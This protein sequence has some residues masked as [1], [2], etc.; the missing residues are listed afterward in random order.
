MNFQMHTFYHEIGNLLLRPLH[1]IFYMTWKSRRCLKTTIKGTL[2]MSSITIGILGATGYTGVELA[3][4]LQKHSHAD[5]AFVSSQDLCGKKIQ[6]GISG[7]HQHLRCSAYFSGRSDSTEGR[8]CFFVSSTCHIRRSV[9]AFY[10]KRDTGHR[11]KRRLP[12]KKPE[13]VRPM[14]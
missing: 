6:R 10:G 14:V 11:F 2:R 1:F 8:L 5:I 7:T 12:D 13:G 9:H 3:K 4:L